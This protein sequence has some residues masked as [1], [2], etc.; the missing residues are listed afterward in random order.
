MVKDWTLRLI[1][2]IAI[3]LVIVWYFIDRN[4]RL[5]ED[6]TELK[7]GMVAMDSLLTIYQTQLSACR[8]DRDELGY[9]VVSMFDA[10][11]VDHD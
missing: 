11:E 7:A 4:E 9:A 1:A 6:N 10:M 3:L 2:V 8:A 5:Q